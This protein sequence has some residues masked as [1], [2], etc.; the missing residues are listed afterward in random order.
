MGNPSSHPKYRRPSVKDVAELAGVS[1]TT[2]S[3]VI[4]NHP[5]VRPATRRRVEDAI[6]TLGYQANAAGRQLRQGRSGTIALALPRIASAKA[7]LLIE[8]M[9]KQAE[10]LGWGVVLEPT[11]SNKSVERK[12]IQGTTSRTV[13]GVVLLPSAISGREIARHHLGIPLVLVGG[14]VAGAGVDHI[15]IDFD[16]AAAKIVDHLVSTGRESIAFLGHNLGQS[17]LTGAA[18]LAAIAR[19]MLRLPN[20]L[21]AGHV[22]SASGDTREAGYRTIVTNRSNL[23]HVDALVCSNEDLAIG[24]INGLIE[25]GISIPRDVA[26]VGW[27]GGDESKFFI[28]SITSTHCDVAELAKVTLNALDGRINGDDA[29]PKELHIDHVLRVGRSTVCDA[30]LFFSELADPHRT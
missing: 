26:V 19:I 16:T 2:V 30:P 29:A 25:M 15:G 8:S 18:Q 7:A 11:F 21:G 20:G 1:W 10:E 17:D 23:N 12:I 6:R 9:V 27:D 14:G 28:P 24:V 13:D 22:F 4:H 3:N 5:H